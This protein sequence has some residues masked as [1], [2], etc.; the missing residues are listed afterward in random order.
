MTVHDFRICP[1]AE[2]V[3]QAGADYIGELIAECVD[4]GGN[5]HVALPGGSTPARCLELLS[6]KKLPWQKVHWYLGDERCY[7]RGHPERNDTMIEHQLWSRIES[8]PENIHPIPAELGPET[9]AE[10]YAALIVGIGGLDIAVLG[11]GEDGHTASLFPGNPA[12]DS[13]LAAVAVYDAPKPPA[14]RVWLGLATVQ[15][16]RRRVVLVAGG[17]K[18]EALAGV[19]RDEPLPVNLIGPSVWFVDRAAAD[20]MDSE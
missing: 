8:P 7:P 11:M 14:E 15:A 6:R 2:S 12:T 1:D 3:A 17:G 9:A 13:A 19:A 4:A 16:A 18:R 20:K 10:S 5:C